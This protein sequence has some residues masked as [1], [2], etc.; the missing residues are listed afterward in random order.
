MFFISV[1]FHGHLVAQDIQQDNDEMNSLLEQ[2]TIPSEMFTLKNGLRV[3]VN[4]DRY[5][6]MI[7]VRTYYHVGGK[8]EIKGKTGFAHLFEHLM[9]LGSENFPDFISAFKEV[10]AT[11]YNGTTRYDGTDYI[12]TIPKSALE[13]GLLLES[14]RMGYLLGAVTQQSLDQQRGVVKN[15]LEQKQTGYIEARVPQLLGLYPP[16]HPYSHHQAGSMVDI[17]AASLDDVRFWFKRYY[18]AA[19]AVIAVTG[20]IDAKTLKPLMEKYFAEIPAG[21]SLTKKQQ[22]VA[23]RE[24]NKL[25]SIEL[26]VPRVQIER[27]WL[28]PGYKAK[29]SAYFEVI[30]QL[31]GD[32]K[33]GLLQKKLVDEA[34]IATYASASVKVDELSSRFD[35]VVNLKKKEYEAQANRLIDQVVADFIKEGPDEKQLKQVR[36]ADITTQLKRIQKLNYKATDLVISVALANDNDHLNK[37]LK[38]RHL[39]SIETLRQTAEKW[40]S[41]GYYQITINPRAKYSV[42]KNKADRSKLPPIPQ[43][44]SIT[45]PDISSFRLDNGIQVYFA[46]HDRAPVANISLNFNQGYANVPKEK[47]G[48]AGLTVDMMK[49]GSQNYSPEDIKK[50][51]AVQGGKLSAYSSTES[52][53]VSMELIATQLSSSVELLFDFVAKPKFDEETF[54][55]KKSALI[56]RTNRKK[57]NRKA[58]SDYLYGE[59][60][61]YALTDSVTAESINNISLD[62]VTN[63]YQQQLHPDNLNIVVTGKTSLSAIKTLLNN[64]FGQWRIVGKAKGKV[65]IKPAPLPQKAQ[66]LLIHSDKAKLNAISA[67]QLVQGSDDPSSFKLSLINRILG[68]GLNS[69]L[70]RNL[71]TDKGWSFSVSSGV[72]PRTTQSYWSMRT[73]VSK[74][75]TIDAMA[76]MHKELSQLIS[77]KPITEAEVKGIVDGTVLSLP[78]RFDTATRVAYAISNKVVVGRPADDSKN[79]LARYLA[80][81]AE[82]LNNVAK[83][84]FT[85]NNLVWIISGNVKHLEEKINALGWGEATLLTPNKELK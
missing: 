63:F 10:G 77:T 54:D 9:L 31:L 34:G 76:E 4:T 16:N 19:N 22:W 44:E 81:N 45:F 40:L 7:A 71:R 11:G 62:D 68:R 8:D 2:L 57:S 64:T 32:R 25:E 18:G 1:L 58:I 30:A 66:I 43:P 13:R 50:Q 3:V 83:S 53:I 24:Q 35:I 41:Y 23:T 59:E 60:H 61:S 6:P 27:S 48:L 70:T 67:S 14:D 52:T 17:N 28:L 36:L 73:S 82:Q 42:S 79:E 80:V 20:D 33:T 65:K 72:T 12:F 56:A 26:D 15:E 51:L 85:P 84:T 75:N 55:Q 21:P 69:R 5:T 46:Q 39:S 29:D 37:R 49:Q 74:E 78:M 47:E 38:W